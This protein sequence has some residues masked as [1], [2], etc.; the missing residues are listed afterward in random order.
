MYVRCFD[1]SQG[2]NHELGVILLSIKSF[3]DIEDAWIKDLKA[4]NNAKI[5]I[6]NNKHF[7]LF[8]SLF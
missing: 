2:S 3:K 5:K 6:Q 1:D 7:R 8:F 4:Q